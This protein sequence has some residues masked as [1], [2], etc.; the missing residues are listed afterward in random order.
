[1]L[2]FLQVCV[3]V[4][5]GPKSR[6]CAY[7]FCWKGTSF[8][9]FFPTSPSSRPTNL[10][11]TELGPESAYS[12]VSGLLL[13]WVAPFAALDEPVLQKPIHVQPMKSENWRE[14]RPP[15]KIDQEQAKERGI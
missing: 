14:K 2:R 12:Q 6:E 3:C 5:S 7:I 4:L 8:V 13:A 10:E 11:V 15:P 1:M 9:A